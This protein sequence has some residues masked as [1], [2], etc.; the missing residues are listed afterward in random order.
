MSKDKITIIHF[1]L[2]LIIMIFFIWSFIKPINYEIWSMEVL[3]AVAVIILAI[4]IYPTFRL[5]TLSYIIITILT[6]LMSIGGHYSYAKVPL[7]DWIK[8]HFDLQRNHYDR[9]GHF[10]KGLMAIVIREIL[11]RLTPLSIGKWLI[12]ITFCITLSIGALYEIIEWAGTKLFGGG[13][14]SK[15]FLGMQGDI[16]DAQWDMFLL[17]FG[18][19]LALLFLSKIHTKQMGKL[20]KIKIEK[21]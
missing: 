5:T 19:I 2:L 3:P 21:K 17:A 12:L 10:L 18:T 13:M 8:D 9:L 6:I 7:F 16:W 4:K 14:P 15:E 11:L 1:F 20:I